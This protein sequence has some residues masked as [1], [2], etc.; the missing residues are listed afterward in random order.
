M[1]LNWS[2]SPAHT[3]LHSHNHPTPAPPRGARWSGELMGSAP[4]S[5]RVGSAE[6]K[7]SHPQCRSLQTHHFAPNHCC[8]SLPL[9][10]R[11]WQ[12]HRSLLLHVSALERMTETCPFPPENDQRKKKRFTTSRLLW[13]MCRKWGKLLMRNLLLEQETHHTLRMEGQRAGLGRECTYYTEGGQKWVYSCM[14]NRVHS[15]L[16]Y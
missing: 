5:H 8:S 14:W 9:R 13:L 3:A 7:V 11:L 12:K 15:R 1:H 2:L 4:Q 10:C 6:S 16:I